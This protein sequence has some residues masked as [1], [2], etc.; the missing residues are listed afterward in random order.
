[1]N[2]CSMNNPF[3]YRVKC[4]YWFKDKRRNELDGASHNLKHS[5]QPQLA[6]VVLIFVSL[7]CAFFKCCKCVFVS[8]NRNWKTSFKRFFSA[9]RVE[10]IFDDCDLFVTICMWM[11]Q[12]KPKN[13]LLSAI[14]Q[15]QF[16]ISLSYIFCGNKWNLFAKNDEVYGN[17]DIF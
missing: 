6:I 9:V 8:I 11:K 15:S 14:K 4:C 3:D 13:R 10:F 17:V 5:N 7:K 2:Y 1:M 16:N 12:L